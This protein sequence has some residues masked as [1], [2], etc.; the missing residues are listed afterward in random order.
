MK[1]NTSSTDLLVVGSVAFDNI[2]TPF[3]QIENALG[4][5]ATYIS[6]AANFFNRP[7]MVAVVGDDFSGDYRR[8]FELNQIDL[9]GLEQAPGKTFRWGGEYNFDM[10]DR[11][12]LFTELNVFENFQ[13][14]LADHHKNC[15]YIFLGNIHPSVQKEVLAQIKQPK[16]IGL[17]TMNYWIE[18]TPLELAG[19]LNL[20]DVLIINDTEARQLS[21]EHNLVKAARKILGFMK[22]EKNATLIIKRGEY[23]L[24]LFHKDAIFH[25]PGFLLEDVV[26]PTG[27]GDSFAGGFMGFLAKTGD[28][29]FENLKRACV[30]GSVMASF[31]VENLGTARLQNLTLDEINK[32]YQGFKQLT[33]FELY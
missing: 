23:G 15:Q 30:Y 1:N 17:D 16:F 28:L 4:G 6:L 5:S 27:A 33:H 18:K 19:T 10:N 20:T 7:S 9:S 12:T 26:D 11:R 32:R 24:L 29:S 13:P 3:G 25:L 22:Q 14:K 8:I 2:K 31:C 21:E